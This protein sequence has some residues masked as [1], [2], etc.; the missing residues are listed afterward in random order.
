MANIKFSAFTQKVA[1]ADVDFLVGYTGADNVRIT[2]A[3]L[4]DGIYLPLGGGTMTG[5]LE[6]IDNIQ[7]QMGNGLDFRL[8]HDASNSVISSGTGDLYIQ[9]TADDKDIIFKSDDGSGG[10]TTYFYLDGS[11]GGALP[12]TVFPDNSNLTFGTGYDLRQY[13]NGIDS[14]LDNYEGNLTIRN[15]ADDKDIIFQSDDG[16]GGVTP[17]ITLDGSH[18]TTLIQKKMHFDDNI[19]LTFGNYATPD[20]E[21]YHDGSN[22]YISDTGTG[23]LRIWSDNP[24]ISTAAGN[25]IFYGNNGA[26]ELYYTGAVKKFE[27]TAT[28]IQVTDEVSIGTSIIHTGDTDTKI[29]FGT[30]EIVLTTA[31]V[32]RM[33]V[34]SNGNI[35][36]GNNNPNQSGLGI[37]HTVVTIGTATGMGMMELTG[38]RT[39]DADLGRI[40][41]LNA[42]TRRSEIVVSRID[43]NTSTKMAFSTSNAGSMGTRMT[44]A[45][46]GDVGIGTTTPLFK[47]HTYRDD[48]TATPSVT[49]EQDGTGDAS[50]HFLLSGIVGWSAGLD[51]S[52]GDKF[53]IH[54][55]QGFSGSFFTIDGSGDVGIGETSVDARLH[56]SSIG[57]SGISNIKL[58]SG[59]SSKW[60]FGIPAGQTYLAFDETNDS[61]STPTMVLTKTTKRVGIGDTNPT[62]LLS[63]SDSNGADLGF[64]NSSVLSDGDYLGRIYGIDSSSNFFTGINMFYHD[65]NDGEIRFR[66]KTA[67]T[68]TDVMTLVDGSVGIGTVAPTAALQVVGLVEYADNAAALLAGLTAG[69]FYRTGDL[70]KVVH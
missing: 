50:I 69:A 15:Y 68:N 60:A 5:D 29:S 58:E 26:A 43:E 20:L 3:A 64:S 37:D 54:N 38:T 13:H 31:G 57:G 45:K 70:L 65:S 33:T 46:D 41:W 10:I 30:D 18:T 35:G 62:Y 56:I 47:L 4:G 66:L 28:G 24:N 22:S 23:D 52:D 42:A 16:A 59:G 1:Q 2:P 7:L 63:L 36:I 49:I 44:I 21:I 6:I 17:Y 11:A 40:A 12:F 32:D 53:K 27:T 48:A 61:L 51:N 55:S 34:V 25:K 14:Y 19:K 8:Y 39:S 67:G 9:N